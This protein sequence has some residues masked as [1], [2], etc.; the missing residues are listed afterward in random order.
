MKFVAE[1][2]IRYCEAFSKPEE[3]VLAELERETWLKA[4][5]PQML[6][7]H[8]QGKFLSMVSAMI[9]PEAVLELGTFTGY[10]AICLAAGLREGGVLHTIEADEELE[11]LIRKYIRKSGME[12]K[13]VLHIGKAETL[14]PK[15]NRQFDLVFIDA[16]KTAYPEYYKLVFSK[17]KKG[18]YILA[19]NALW[20]GKVLEE[21]KDE[22]T[23]G[24]H[25]FNRMVTD[26][27]RVDNVLL[28]L[29]DGVM[30]V[31]KKV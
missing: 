5:Y 18:G 3:K 17:V 6:S 15:L 2:I 23:R 11:E 31:R 22:E 26:D 20:S 25:K 7:G 14:I 16:D 8:L 28:P 12:K 9:Q 30:M 19:D 4:M 10:S 27:K 1:S 13:I 24:I 29:R 21:K